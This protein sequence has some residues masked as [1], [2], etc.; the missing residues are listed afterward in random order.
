MPIGI[1]ADKDTVFVLPYRTA[2]NF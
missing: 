1:R 2:C